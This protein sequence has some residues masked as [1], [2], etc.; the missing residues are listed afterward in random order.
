MIP[1]HEKQSSI[2][3]RAIMREAAAEGWSYSQLAALLGMTKGQVAGRA[4]RYGVKFHCGEMPAEALSAAAIATIRRREAEPPKPA[5][6]PS[7]RGHSTSVVQARS[8]WPRLRATC[9]WSGCRA[10]PVEPGKPYCREHA[11]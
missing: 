2:P 10:P 4:R 11:K 7:V 5:P 8:E 1:R 6:S 9:C 3:L